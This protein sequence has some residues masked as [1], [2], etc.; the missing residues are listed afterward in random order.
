MGARI[1]QTLIHVS[2]EQTNLLAYLRFG[3][4]LAQLVCMLWMTVLVVQHAI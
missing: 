4:F 1:M 3:F 2:R